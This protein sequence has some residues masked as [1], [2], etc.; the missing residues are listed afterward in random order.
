MKRKVLLLGDPALYEVSSAVTR[1]ELEELRPDIEDMF[2]CL[3]DA[4]FGHGSCRS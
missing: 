2:E 3:K 4:G 1:E